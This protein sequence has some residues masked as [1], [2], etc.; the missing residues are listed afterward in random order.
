MVYSNVRTLYLLDPGQQTTRLV[1]WKAL[2][3]VNNF[4]LSFTVCVDRL[5]ALIGDSVSPFSKAWYASA[6][7]SGGT[8]LS[9]KHRVS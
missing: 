3:R 2:T 7:A 4:M 8:P 9:R 6:T 5:A 1:T